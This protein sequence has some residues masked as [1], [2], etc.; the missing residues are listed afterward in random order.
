MPVLIPETVL[1]LVFLEETERLKQ[2]LQGET[3]DWKRIGFNKVTEVSSLLEAAC[4]LQCLAGSLEP[5]GHG[6]ELGTEGFPICC[7]AKRNINKSSWFT[8]ACRYLMGTGTG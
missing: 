8:W 6:G 5:L 4:T 7:V 2:M 3:R 1:V